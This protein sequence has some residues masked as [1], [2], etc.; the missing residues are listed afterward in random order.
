MI[1]QWYP[2][3]LTQKRLAIFF[4]ATAISGALSGL[5]AAAITKMDGLGGYEAWRWIFIIEG[6]ISLVLGLSCF[7]VL[8]DS[9]SLSGRWLSERE[10]QFLNRLHEEHR[11]A[12]KQPEP[13][14]EKRHK[15][16]RAVLL[17]VLA[18]WQIYLQSLIFI[19]SLMPAY[20]LKFTMPQIILNS[21]QFLTIFS[22]F[23]I[24]NVCFPFF[25]SLLISE[26][27]EN[28]I[29][30]HLLSHQILPATSKLTL[31]T[32]VGFTNIQAQLLTAPP[33]VCGA[34]S[35]VISSILADKLTWRLPFIV[36]PQALLLAGF[37]LLFRLSADITAN[38]A[39]CYFCVHLTCIGTF[40]ISP[41]ASAWLINNLATPPKRAV[42]VALMVAIGNIGGIVGSVIFQDR[43]KPRYP[44]GWGNCLAFAA[45][46][47]VAALTLE[48][49]YFSINK[50]RARRNE[51]EVREKYDEAVLERMGDR[52][53]LFRYSL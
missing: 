11:A 37:A 43:E 14:N 47:M 20:A 15:V 2:P 16:Q 34:I 41:G 13:E 50:K 22:C 31:G 7:F 32:A 18:D 39:V 45:A 17:S 8:P 25:S 6:L 1:S 38:V 40:P 29:I 10:V 49:M 28:S 33:Y 30:F 12:R 27:S 52:S 3:H 46:G 19:S 51:E 26:L 9:P 53:P 44:T 5:L 4:A 36:G 23:V 35:A 21:R 48:V 42:G 24:T